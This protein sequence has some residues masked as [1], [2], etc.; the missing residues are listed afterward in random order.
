MRTFLALHGVML[1]AAACSTLPHAPGPESVGLIERTHG[2]LL[3]ELASGA[4]LTDTIVLVDLPSL[5]TREVSRS[6]RALDSSA[7]D[8]QGRVVYVVDAQKN[9]PGR[10][11]LGFLTGVE[12]RRLPDSERWSL[13]SV[14]FTHGRDTHL[15]TLDSGP[16]LPSLAPRGGRVVLKR[17]PLSNLAAD[18]VFELIDLASLTVKKLDAGVG[19]IQSVDWL[20][21]GES[22]A[23]TGT[24]GGAIVAAADGTMLERNAAGYGLFTPDGRTF[25]ALRDG[26]HALVD[27]ESGEVRIASARMP[28]PIDFGGPK[29]E[30]DRPLPLGMCGPQLVLYP[31]LPTEGTKVAHSYMYGGNF[32]NENEVVKVCDIATG[33]FTTVWQGSENVGGWQ[34][35]PV[36]LPCM[37][38]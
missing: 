18:G 25:L 8:D 15:L 28:F 7:V 21:D 31:A 36:R 38:R 26:V 12:P 1:L 23:L 34:F 27:R 24:K 32:R 19:A 22:V 13:R 9:R 3:L 35:A 30:N 2:S 17:F 14:E 33:D 5:R 4:E 11:I 16:W 6:K 20:P 37:V 10:N 29:L